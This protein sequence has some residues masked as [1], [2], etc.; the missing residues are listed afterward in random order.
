EGDWSRPGGDFNDYV[1]ARTE[2]DLRRSDQVIA[3]D[4]SVMF[5]EMFEELREYHGIILTVPPYRGI[6]VD[7]ET[8]PAL[9]RFGDARLTVEYRNLLSVPPGMAALRAQTVR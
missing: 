4:V 7:T 2:V 5:S 3:F 8:V 6:G 1:Y 9:A